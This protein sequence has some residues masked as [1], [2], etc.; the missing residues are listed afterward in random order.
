MDLYSDHSKCLT[1]HV[2]HIHSYTDGQSNHTRSHL[3]S[4]HPHTD[5]T[6]FGSNLGVQ[7]SH[8]HGLEEPGFNH[9]Y[10]ARPALTSEPQSPKK[11]QHH[12]RAHWCILLRTQHTG[13]P[14]NNLVFKNKYWIVDKREATVVREERW[15]MTWNKSHMAGHEM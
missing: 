3:L 12:I 5:G 10:E 7:V 15:G 2:T 8:G 4:K 9:L 1:L 13:S 11:D 14:A 6:A